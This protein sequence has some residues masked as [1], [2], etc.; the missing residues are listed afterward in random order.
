ML[1]LTPLLL[2]LAYFAAMW[3]FSAWR[4][5]RE[6]AERSSPMKHPRLTP[7]LDR[8][9]AAMELPRIQAWIYEVPMM[10]GLAAPDGRIFVTR[11]FIEKMDRGE[12]SP[13]EIAGVVAH[14]L[15]HVAHGHSRRRMIDFAGQNVIRT[16]LIGTI[17]RFVPFIGPWLINLA[18]AAIAARLSQQDEFEADRF[19]TALLIKSGIGA[20]PQISLFEKLDR[21]SGGRRS[22]SPAWLLSHPHTEKR[23]AA[24]RANLARWQ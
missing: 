24:I 20:A 7:L 16:L 14:E 17:G 15:G 12:V 23:V 10:N 19:A 3:F 4:M 6:L 9:G 18:T 5:K 13:E 2:V 11:G 21:L 22:A 1:K 8:L